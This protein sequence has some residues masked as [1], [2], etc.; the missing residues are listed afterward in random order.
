M[1]FSITQI[2]GEINFWDSRSA[3]SAILTN[4]EASNF[5]FL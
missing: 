3:E 1:M 2:L 5:D 4:L